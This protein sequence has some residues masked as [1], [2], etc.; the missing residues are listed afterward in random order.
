MNRFG[1]YELFIKFILSALCSPE[2]W[3]CCQCWI[4]GNDIYEEGTFTWTSD[5]NTFGFVSWYPYQPSDTNN[6]DYVSI[7]RDGHWADCSCGR[8]WPYICKAPTI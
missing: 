8:V 1:V 7:C 2:W 4:G 3:N 5:N 6:Q